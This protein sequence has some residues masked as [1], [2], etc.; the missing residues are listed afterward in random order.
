MM[1]GDPSPGGKEAERRGAQEN[2][3]VE[4]LERPTYETVN[5]VDEDD[6]TAAPH[7]DE[8][9]A[10]EAWDDWNSEAT[11]LAQDDQDQDALIVS[12]FEDSLIDVLQSDPDTASC[13][14]TYL[15][16][17]RRIIEKGK[18]RGFWPIKGA[19]GGKSKPK[20]KFSPTFTKG[21]GHWKAECPKRFETE[22][23]TTPATTAFAGNVMIEYEDGDTEVTRQSAEQ[24][25]EQAFLHLKVEELDHHKIDFGKEKK[26]QTYLKVVQ[27]DPR[28]TAWFTSTYKNSTKGPH[29]KFIHYVSL[30]TDRLEQQLAKGK[31]PET[32][33]KNQ[34][35]TASKAKSRRPIM[36]SPREWQDR[37]PSS[38]PSPSQKSS[39]WEMIREES[40]Q[41]N[42]RISQIE[43]ALS[44]MVQQLQFVTSHLNPTDQ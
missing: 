32:Q 30:Y 11:F 28:Y 31:T 24:H 38:S 14:H 41:Q 19:P 8:A 2:F 37:T 7:E 3:V 15:E 1:L 26:G 34:L 10:H 4:A 36:T 12:Q 33:P 44:Q 13:Y 17:R 21:K 39:H 6:Q 16:A 25:E 5:A 40:V 20:G 27:E 35:G 29:R 9:F 42:Q 22:A 18:N 23:K 43:G